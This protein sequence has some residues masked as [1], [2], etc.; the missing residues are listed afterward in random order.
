MYLQVVNLTLTSVVFEY[1]C[2]PTNNV[3]LMDLTLTSVVFEC[4]DGKCIVVY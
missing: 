2:W 3:E 4:I 1:L